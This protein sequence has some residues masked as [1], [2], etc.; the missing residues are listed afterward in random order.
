[1]IPVPLRRLF[2]PAR[3]NRARVH[4]GLLAAGV[5]FAVATVAVLVQAVRAADA[6]RPALVP[7][8]PASAALTRLP[9]GRES[10]AQSRWD[11]LLFAPV[12][13]WKKRG[14]EWTGQYTLEGPNFD[15]SRVQITGHWAVAL[16]D[17]GLAG[18]ADANDKSSK[19]YIDWKEETPRHQGTHPAGYKTLTTFTSVQAKGYGHDARLYMLDVFL[20]ANGMA[21]RLHYAAAYRENFD[22]HK[23]VFDEF[24][25]STRLLSGVVLAEAFADQ[26]PLEQFTINQCCD[27]V[28]WLLDVPLTDTQRQ[29]AREHLT[30]AWKRHDKQE[31]AGLWEVFKARDELN[32]L[33]GDKKELARVAARAEV[34]KNWREEAN[35][36]DAMARLMVEV[37]DRAHQPLAQ[38]RQGEP[39]LTRQQSDATLEILHFMASKVAGFDVGPSNQQKADFAKN[40][41]GK[42]AEMPLE[43]KKE[44]EQMPLYWA[45]LRAAWPELPADEQAKLTEQWSAA[46]P[47]KPIITQVNDLKAK[48][49]ASGNYPGGYADALR[50]LYHQQQTTAMISNMMAMQH[51]TNMMIINNIGSSNYR[52]E[53]RYV[54][55]YR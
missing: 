50:R 2:A 30:A 47:I 37:Y 48:A 14:Q 31:A 21:S 18:L 9:D 52:Y 15:K 13:G 45:W 29:A 49:I 19:F 7:L 4:P 10:T 28:E 27:F 42:Y 8:R 3:S 11:N 17:K 46:E 24:L 34:I 36:G 1:M 6:S 20:E 55:R 16:D 53:Y 40:L 22:R 25:A 39:P 41:T 33:K 26:P 5:L 44:L 38:G 12:P 54:Y 23:P 35:T 51:R 43:A 32:K